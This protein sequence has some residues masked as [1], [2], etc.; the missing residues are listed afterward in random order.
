MT[1]RDAFQAVLD[2]LTGCG[3]K[4][5]QTGDTA[6]AQCPAHS[7]RNPSLSI[8]RIEGQ[9]LLHCHAGCHAEDVLT[10]LDLTMR[11]LFDDPKG[12]TYNYGD[13]RRVHRDPFKNFRQSGKTKGTAELYRLDKVKRAVADNIVVYVAEGEKDVHAL[14]SLGA[15]ATC[16]PMGAGKWHL[17]DSTPL[18]GGFVVI[19]ADR[20]EAGIAHA[21]DII[22]SLGNGAKV[23]SIDVVEAKVGKDAAD[24]IAA[25]HG[26]ADFQPIPRE[27]IND[28][29]ANRAAVELDAFLA[30][31]T[32]DHA[33]DWLIPGLLEAGDRLILTGPEG[34]GKSTLLRQIA[35]QA[36]SGIHPFTL[37]SNRPLRI[38]LL[39]LENGRRH[40]RRELRPLR[41]KA[42]D[43]YKP[44]PGLHVDVRPEG[45]DILDRADAEW[46]VERVAEIK[47]DILITGPTYKLAGGD[48]IEEKTARTVASWLDRIRHDAGCA[49]I[50]EA[51]TPYSN[52]RGKRPERPYGASLWSRWPEFG[53]YLAKEGQL[54]HWRGPRDERN[55]PSLLQRGGAWPWT[56]VDRPHDRI[57]AQI[58]ELCTEAGA[59]LTER[60]LAN[61]T[62]SSQP[63][64]HRVIKEHEDQWNRL[65]L[66]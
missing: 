55:W 63:T 51:H 40:V 60:D 1:G 47:P 61:L 20:D 14:E 54:R 50:I 65:D 29:T 33:Y 19:V 44:L 34:G 66:D 11:D 9:V 59:R 3:S 17:A 13:G 15:V 49:L 37:E 6:M 46:L 35:V 42:G 26:L 48:P 45:L 27:R 28:G 39:D 58:V 25:G 30:E 64:V 53:L 36:A 10:T 21:R 52:G 56:V 57:W 62:G 22:D 12:A 7:D 23:Q 8:R 16:S 24:H 4:V 2:A 18:H 31:E 38:Y 32:D 43:G 41:A 5:R